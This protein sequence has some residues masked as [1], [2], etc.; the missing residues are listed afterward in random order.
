MKYLGPQ[1]DDLDIATSRSLFPSKTKAELGSTYL[2][3]DHFPGMA[4]CTD[5]SPPSPVFSFNGQWLMMGTFTVVSTDPGPIVVPPVDSAVR[6]GINIAGAEYSETVIPGSEGTNYDIT[7]AQNAIDWKAQGANVIRFPFQLARCFDTPGGALNAAGKAMIAKLVANYNAA[8]GGIPYILDGHDYA[9]RW[10][11][12]AMRQLGSS[13]YPF[14]AL[15]SDWATLAAYIEGNEA[16]CGIDFINEPNGFSNL[17]SE[18]NYIARPFKQLMRDPQYR[19]PFPNLNWYTTGPFSV[20]KSVGATPGKMSWN[21]SNVTQ[22]YVR[23]LDGGGNNGGDTLVAGQTYTVSFW[24]QGTVTAGTHYMRFSAGNYNT[25]GG[26]LLQS[27]LIPAAASKTRL[28]VQITM[29]A[30]QTKLYYN[31]DMN[32]FSGVG[33]LSDWNITEGTALRDFVPWSSDGTVAVVSTVMNGCIAAV[34]AAGYTGWC[35]WEGDRA[36]GL[37]DFGTNYGFWPDK[38]W[39]DP[40]DK[41]MMSVHHYTD[42]SGAY[43]SAWTQEERDRILLYIKIMSDWNSAKDIRVQVG[44]WAPPNDA[45]ADSVQRRIDSI[46]AADAYNAAGWDHTYFAAGVKPGSFTSITAVAVDSSKGNTTNL[47]I[48][49]SH[50]GGSGGTTPTPTPSDAM[51]YNGNAITNDGD[52]VT[53]STGNVSTSPS[54]PTTPTNPTTP[55][56]P[57]T[58]AFGMTYNGN[59]I[60]NDDDSVTYNGDSGTNGSTTPASSTAVAYNGTSLTKD[61]TAVTQN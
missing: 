58:S 45:S 34:R 6:R 57:T 8:G 3:G 47:S 9:K 17:S 40:L 53:Y 31:H 22:P 15:Y 24:T 19:S 35:L 11:S 49:T 5:S 51:T 46:T 60:T 41:T 28:S 29:P 13:Q 14:S 21:A 23:H 10:V 7:T 25:D 27:V 39:T 20:T 36:S 1:D 18:F 37:M 2:A 44:E 52:S 42:Y 32:A 38:M 55:T 48:V 26:T 4:F 54:S 30:G 59:G 50:F 43:T 33:E 61:G 56:T 12:G 16:F